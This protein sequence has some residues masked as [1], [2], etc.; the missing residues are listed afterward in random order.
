[1]YDYGLSVLEQYGLEAQAVY[2]GR[3]A[4]IC[5]TEKGLKI[6]K[7]FKGSQK[8]LEQLYRLQLHI[9]QNSDIAVDCVVE[10]LEG[11][12]VSQDKDGISYVVRDWFGG[13][14]CDTKSR[15]DILES[16]KTLAR[17]HSVMCLPLVENYRKESLLEECSRH[18]R[19][20]RKT[21]TYIKKKKTKNEFERRLLGCLKDFLDQGEQTVRDLGISCYLQLYEKETKKGSICHGECNQHNFLRGERGTMLVN[22][23]KWNFDC[24]VAD[25]YQFMRK[26]LEKHNW[27]V[28]LGQ[29][30][31]LA[32][33]KEKKLTREEVVNL[34]L[35]LSYPWKFW[36]LVNHYA[37]SSKPWISGRNLEKLE[38]LIK[39]Q[40]DWMEFIKNCFSDSF[41]SH[42][43]L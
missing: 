33:H 35:R 3:G 37:G 13:R 34:K 1:M 23:E 28:R 16:V 22:Y 14:E 11:G 36:K 9:R 4:L 42:F 10:N 43:T 29:D 26:I 38:V 31:I 17:L 6:I 15:N 41:F 20:I 32:Y 27:N 30:M 18:N 25:L 8:K 12:L 39:Q 21:G 40:K 2:R 24:Q 5:E 19:E 7:E